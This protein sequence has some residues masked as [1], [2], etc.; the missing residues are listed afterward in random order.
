MAAV[1]SAH[2]MI[3]TPM[4]SDAPISPYKTFVAGA[5]LVEANTENIAISTEIPGIVSK[6]YVSKGNQVKK[7]EPLF[8]I[9]DRATRSL[10]TQQQA[11][12]KVA[13]AQLD[14]AKYTNEVNQGLVQKYVT[15]KVDA[16]MSQYQV[17]ICTAQL[18][19]A[20]ATAD[21][22]S[23]NLEIMT[24]RAPVDGQV[25]Q[26]HIHPGEYAAAG[27]ASTPL[28]LFGNTDP[29]YVRTDID[30][31]EA[32]R[33]RDNAQAVG[34]LRGNKEICVPLKFVQF[35]PYV[36][37]KISL[38]GEPTERVDTRVMQAIYSMPIGE[39]RIRA[40]Q[41]VDVFIEAA[42]RNGELSSSP[43]PQ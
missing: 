23:T 17:A 19:Q 10:L 3:P 42:P 14:E 33:V 22:T 8:T 41:Q 7:G 18:E 39:K 16:N 32:W 25:L 24:V 31:N 37:P 27:V 9:D 28:I 15:A 1:K 43:S 6:I 30:E 35:E 36:I 38:T 26:L 2:K 40:G 21:Q 29:L 11:A 12:V 20:I 4:V 5:G 34:F 13:R